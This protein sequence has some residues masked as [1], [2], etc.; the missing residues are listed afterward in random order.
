MTTK[1]EIL[2]N[3]IVV[4]VQVVSELTHKDKEG[5]HVIASDHQVITKRQRRTLRQTSGRRRRY[6]HR[7]NSSGSRSDSVDGRRTSSGGGRVWDQPGLRLSA[8]APD[9]I[10][11]TNQRHAVDVTIW[12]G[13]HFLHTRILE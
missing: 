2:N 10:L 5:H 7:C 8:R 1:V 4:V 9:S 6:R 12:S 11:Q 3:L 13:Q